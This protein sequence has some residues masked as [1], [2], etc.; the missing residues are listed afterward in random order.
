MNFAKLP[1]DIVK[2]F[3]LTPEDFQAFTRK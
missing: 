3:E 2:A 1:P